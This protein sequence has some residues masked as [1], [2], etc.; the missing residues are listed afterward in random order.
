M[1]GDW[2]ARRG[3]ADLI[4]RTCLLAANHPPRRSTRRGTT[5][6]TKHT[7]NTPTDTPPKFSGETITDESMAKL[8]ES[9]RDALLQASGIRAMAA[10]G[11]ISPATA[12][13]YLN[14]QIAKLKEAIQ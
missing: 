2:S 9:L 8:C 10:T 7:M 11:D 13:R 12:A 3:T 14:R 6:T 5:N 1:Q 4:P